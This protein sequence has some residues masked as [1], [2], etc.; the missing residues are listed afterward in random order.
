MTSYNRRA[1]GHRAPHRGRSDSQKSGVFDDNR[2]DE[3]FATEEEESHREARERLRQRGRSQL[4][5]KPN[6]H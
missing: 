4:L 6:W 2:N 1:E 3:R 5:D